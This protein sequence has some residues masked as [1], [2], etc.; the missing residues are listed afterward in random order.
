MEKRE[1]SVREIVNGKSILTEHVAGQIVS[2]M[3]IGA[4]E[5]PGI[6]VSRH[7]ASHIRESRNQVS[8]VGNVAAV[9]DLQRRDIVSVRQTTE[10]QRMS[11]GT[12]AEESPH[13]H[14]RARTA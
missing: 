6:V 3:F 2:P 14:I 11:A 10:P 9:E 7:F 5:D 8:S 1:T 4:G 13:N 12:I